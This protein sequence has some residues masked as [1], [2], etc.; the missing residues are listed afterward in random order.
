MH[1]YAEKTPKL[2]SPDQGEGPR[3]VQPTGEQRSGVAS[4]Q[5]CLARGRPPPPTLDTPYVRFTRFQ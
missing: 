4:L 5:G 2:A 1:D 3:P